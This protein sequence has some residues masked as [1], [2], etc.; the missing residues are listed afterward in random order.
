[1][2]FPPGWVTAKPRSLPLAPQA[3]GPHPGAQ[4]HRLPAHRGGP[5]RA[6]P[7]RPQLHPFAPPSGL[8]LLTGGSSQPRPSRD[9]PRG[10]GVHPPGKQVRSLREEKQSGGRGSIPDGKPGSGEREPQIGGWETGSHR[11]TPPP[12]PP[13]VP[14]PETTERGTWS[15]LVLLSTPSCLQAQGSCWAHPTLPPTAT[16]KTPILGRVR[17]ARVLTPGLP[18]L[19]LGCGGPSP[20]PAPGALR[21]ADGPSSAHP[22]PRRVPPRGA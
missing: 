13:Q 4:Q 18:H 21:H 8:A 19:H 1:M 22:H 17:S 20:S 6:S 12:S 16:P 10:S 11:A 14:G 3:P 9:S 2:V 7:P 15:F 5:P